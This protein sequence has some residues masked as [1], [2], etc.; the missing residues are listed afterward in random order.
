ME[1]VLVSL[2]ISCILFT[3]CAIIISIV[4]EKYHDNNKV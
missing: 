4:I 3:V 2:F 1:I